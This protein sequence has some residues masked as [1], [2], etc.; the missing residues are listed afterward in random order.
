MDGQ[1]IADAVAQQINAQAQQNQH[2][3]VASSPAV[4]QH[5]QQTPTSAIDNLTCQWQGC[6]ERCDTA[7]ALYVRVQSLLTMFEMLLRGRGRGRDRF[8]FAP[9]AFLRA[10]QQLIQLR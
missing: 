2:T 9:A 8:S 3:Q 5:V 6:G 10:R 4:Q 1:T 7:E